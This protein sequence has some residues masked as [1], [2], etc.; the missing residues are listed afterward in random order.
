MTSD[1]IKRLADKYTLKTADQIPPPL[2]KREEPKAANSNA[3]KEDHEEKR[4]VWPRWKTQLF[5]EM[6]PHSICIVG[7]DQNV[8]CNVENADGSWTQF[9]GNSDT[10][11]PRFNNNPFFDV[12]VQLR[13]WTD[14]EIHAKAFAIFIPDSLTKIADIKEPA[15]LKNGFVDVGYNFD[16]TYFEL[17]LFARAEQAHM[18]LWDDEGLSQY[19]DQLGEQRMRKSGRGL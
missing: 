11:S 7:T 3:P 9:G 1:H 12:R 14:N 5:N 17:D 16:L 19:L 18:R 13:F 10:V 15:K 8:I 4:K 2:P 6:R